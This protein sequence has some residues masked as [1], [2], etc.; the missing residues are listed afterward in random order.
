MQIPRESL[1]LDASARATVP[2][3]YVRLSDGWTRYVDNAGSGIP[4]VLV[5]GFASWSFVWEPIMAA[6][7]AGG[8][9]VIMYDVYGRGYS[10]RPDCS[11][12]LELFTR[13][14][15]ELLVACNV[16]GPVDLLGW[17]MG[18]AISIGFAAQFPDRARRVGVM[19]PAGLPVKAPAAAQLFRLPGL[20]ERI[21][22]LLGP[23]VIR[24]VAKTNLAH[25][26]RREEY[27]RDFIKPC[28][29][30]GYMRS[31]LRT[32]EDFPL[33]DMRE[34]YTAVGNSGHRTMMIWGHRDAICPFSNA[35][36]ATALMPQAELYDFDDMGH[37]C[38]WDDP[39]AVSGVVSAFYH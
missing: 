38:H 28:A 8:R 4:V 1:E 34:A 27:M 33:Y 14:L 35:A 37:A 12:N 19:A 13:Q 18:G 32:F 5:H 10:D 9:R 2:G 7:T 20:G 29:Y 24:N 6:L 31:L 26:E 30:R 3:S 11:Y 23:L 16:D 39:E 36:T 22:P 25:P 15:R 21:A 17:S